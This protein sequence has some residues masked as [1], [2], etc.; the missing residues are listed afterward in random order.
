MCS[1]WSSPSRI[2]SG[3]LVEWIRLSERPNSGSRIVPERSRTEVELPAGTA[4]E[5]VDPVEWGMQ[6][7]GDDGLDFVPAAIMHGGRFT[8]A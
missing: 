8:L 5:T 6:G 7:P 4:R 3:Y 1:V 2:C